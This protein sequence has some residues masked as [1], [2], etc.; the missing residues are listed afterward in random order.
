M[1]KV[2]A[3]RLWC[4][5]INFFERFVVNLFNGCNFCY[6][7]QYTWMGREIE[8]QLGLKKKN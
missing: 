1:L 5:S 3:L 8:W 2:G 7:R 4:K 6:R